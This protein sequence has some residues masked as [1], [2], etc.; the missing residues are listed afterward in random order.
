METT[1]NILITNDDGIQ[2]KGIYELAYMVKDIAKV[3]IVAPDMEKSAVG[4]AITMHSPLRIKE[5]SFKDENIKA[6]AVT[7]TPADCVKLGLEVILKNVKIDLVL[8]GINN[9]PNLGTDVIYSGTVSGAIEALIQ[10]VPAMAISYDGSSI[11]SD[12]YKSTKP[13]ILEIINKF[14]DKLHL[15]DDC[16]LN[17]NI[18]DTKPKGTLY[19][20]LGLRKYENEFEERKD[21]RGNSYYWMGG[22]VKKIKQFE[23]SDVYLCEEGY[24]TIT[25]LFI[26]LTHY[27]KLNIISKEVNFE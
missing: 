25:P 16:V 19:S 27:K 7:G 12:K 14:K 23:D 21:P 17:I 13:Y 11:S 24:I 2:A 20:K 22:V 10:N 4:H 6:Y 5:Y 3:Y 26:D 8:S 9:G 1:V 15:L 18:P